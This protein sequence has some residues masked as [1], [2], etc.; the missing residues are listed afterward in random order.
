[1]KSVNA[2][3]LFVFTVYCMHL[4]DARSGFLL[5]EALAVHKSSQ[6][7]KK[8]HKSSILEKKSIA[9]NKSSKIKVADKLDSSKVTSVK[10]AEKLSD[11]IVKRQNNFNNGQQLLMSILT[12]VLSRLIFKLDYTNQRIVQMCRIAFCMYVILSQVT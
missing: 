7:I 5:S 8:G 4:T 6:A 10:S 2:L 3:V 11:S 12:M 9:H 1:M